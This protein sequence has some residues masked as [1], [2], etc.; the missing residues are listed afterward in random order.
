M[1]NILLLF[2]VFFLLF[3]SVY[4]KYDCPLDSICGNNRFDIRF[5]FGLQRPQNLQHCTYPGFNLKCNNQGRGILN[6]P[7]AGD[8]YVRDINYLMQE[9]QLYDQFDCLPKRLTNFQLPSSSVLK[10]VYYRNYTFLICSTDLVMSFNVISCMSNS[11]ISTLATS[12]TNLASQMVSLYNC[13]VDNTLSIPVSWTPLYE[14]VFSSDLNNDLVLTWDE[15]NCQECEVEGQLC[16][17]KNVTSGEIQC[18]DVA[19]TGKYPF[20]SYTS[21]FSPF[22]NP[23][24]LNL[25]FCNKYCLL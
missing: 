7:G 5:P 15:P 24:K 14:A 13:K 21:I 17:F 8:F 12:S 3:S 16:G 1:D 19:G 23:N 9:I 22:T 11:T 2:F 20:N 6:L 25:L 4:A 18:F 10:P